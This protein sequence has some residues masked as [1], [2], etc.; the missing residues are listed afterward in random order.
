MFVSDFE[1]VGICKNFKYMYHFPVF[2]RIFKVHTLTVQI[3]HW[4]LCNK[5]FETTINTFSLHKENISNKI[6]AGS[7]R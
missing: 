7:F 5:E 2:Y 3:L 1:Y 4:F 6:T